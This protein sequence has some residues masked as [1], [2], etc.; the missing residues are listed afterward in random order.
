[1][2]GYPYKAVG[3]RIG[4]VSSGFLLEYVIYPWRVIN[5]SI[6]LRS[7]VKLFYEHRKFY[8]II[9][10]KFKFIREKIVEKMFCDFDLVISD[11]GRVI[12]IAF[13]RT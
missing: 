1:M 9:E 8:F 12:A 7:D 11:E 3:K 2:S 13:D 4:N 6:R 5:I 10:F